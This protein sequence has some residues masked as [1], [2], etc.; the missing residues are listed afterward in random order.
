MNEFVTYDDVNQAF[1]VLKPFL[2]IVFL[3]S[4]YLWI[5]FIVKLYLEIAYLCMWL[6]QRRNNR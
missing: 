3:P 2:I 6:Y 1:K 4:V 5:S